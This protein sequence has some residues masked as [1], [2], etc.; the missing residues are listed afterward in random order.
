M[1]R[2]DW[3]KRNKESINP[4]TKYTLKEYVDGVILGSADA[5]IDSQVPAMVVFRWDIRNMDTWLT[6]SFLIN[7]K[8]SIHREIPYGLLDGMHDKEDDWYRQHSDVTLDRGYIS[9][10]GDEISQLTLC[11][12]EG[13]ATVH[14]R[15]AILERVKQSIIDYATLYYGSVEE[16]ERLALDDMLRLL[17]AESCR[18]TATRCLKKHLKGKDN[19]DK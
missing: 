7:G 6:I 15:T 10:S 2:P 3:T 18:K 19:V 9:A 5:I 17:E 11:S 12:E 4:D 8:D 16:M 1:K 13:S 14:L